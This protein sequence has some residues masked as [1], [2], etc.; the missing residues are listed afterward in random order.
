MKKL[1]SA[2]L[3]FLLTWTTACGSKPLD[4]SSAAVQPN[5]GQA[6]QTGNQDG[7]SLTVNNAQDLPS[8]TTE[9]EGRMAFIKLSSQFMACNGGAW[10]QIA[11]L[12][13]SAKPTLINTVD[14][15][16][17]ANCLSGGVGIRSGEDTNGS[18]VLDP[19]EG[20][21]ARYVCNGT[22]GMSIAGVWK[23]T[24]SD[25]EDS[26]M[27]GEVSSSWEMYLT[28]IQLVKFSNGG[29]FI[30]V[31]GVYVSGTVPASGSIVNYY[32]EHWSYSAFLEPKTDLQVVKFK[33][34]ASSNRIVALGVNLSKPT[35]ISAS[36]FDNATSVSGVSYFDLWKAQ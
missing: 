12:G 13:S 27:I 34:Q 11:P 35:M 23:Y 10:S 21:A 3:V 18:G 22:N 29:G 36:V 24:N 33:S 28:D 6:T 7:W 8:C 9:T 32:D 16:A 25:P 17:G 26:E 20:G 14:E 2:V 19:N 5:G 31:A 1:S 4:Q 15:P 30:S